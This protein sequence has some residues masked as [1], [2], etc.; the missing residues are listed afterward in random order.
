MRL[1][2]VKRGVKHEDVCVCRLQD[3]EKGSERRAQTLDGLNIANDSR[4]L[5]PWKRKAARRGMPRR[6]ASFRQ[7]TVVMNPVFSIFT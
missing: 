4:W 6:F 1:A 3:G 2:V 5:Q 7:R